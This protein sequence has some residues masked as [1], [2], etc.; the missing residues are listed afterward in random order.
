MLRRYFITGTDTEVG[1]T[2]VTTRLI[3]YLNQH[4]TVA[5][6]FKPIAA[7]A[8]WIDQ[9]WQN[10]DARAIMAVNPVQQEYAS[11]NPFCFEQPIAPHLAAERPPSVIEVVETVNRSLA[12]QQD[13]QVAL[14]EGAGG[15]LVPL[16]ESESFADL[17]KPLNAKVILVVGMRL[18]CISHA[19]LTFEAIQS[20]GLDVVG[21]VAN[22]ID[23]MMSCY[24]ENLAT[25]ERL[26]AAPLLGELK[27]N[28]ETFEQLTQSL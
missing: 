24:A 28:A 4:G 10:D 17:I 27:H 23:P 8:E 19:L 21:W 9:Q 13:I 11:I 1:K 20:R 12:Q 14:I 2:F 16:N 18:G 3:K 15:F 5:M 7:G 26:L 6:G 22:Q 25:L